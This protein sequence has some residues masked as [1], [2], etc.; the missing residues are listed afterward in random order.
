MSNYRANDYIIATC[1]KKDENACFFTVEDGSGNFFSH[2]SKYLANK[3]FTIEKGSKVWARVTGLP[4][5]KCIKA[6]LVQPDEK[7]VGFDFGW[8]GSRYVTGDTFFGIIRE[9]TDSYVTADITANIHLRV[10]KDSFRDPYLFDDFKVGNVEKFEITG[11]VNEHGKTSIRLAPYPRPVD[12]VRLWKRLPE[13]LDPSDVVTDRISID[14]I[15][16]SILTAL[17]GNRGSYSSEDLKEA[18]SKI[19][20]E[21]HKDMTINVEERGS[22]LGINFDSGV[23]K[24]NGALVDVFMEQGFGNR[25]VL[26]AFKH[27][28]A[29]RFMDRYVCITDKKA[30]LDELDKLSMRA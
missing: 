6:T 13:S 20:N 8:L 9:K 24:S 12:A 2:S 4:N 18:V 21:R 28:R 26:K 27:T 23:K 5:G 7:A 1:N 19:Y 14:R 10:K 30:M 11:L 3:G 29:P 17:F 22:V 16:K 15:D 25:W